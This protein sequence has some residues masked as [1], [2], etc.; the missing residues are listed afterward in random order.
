[1]IFYSQFLGLFFFSNIVEYEML[2]D[3]FFFL[4][5]VIFGLKKLQQGRL[6]EVLCR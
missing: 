4:I 5:C 6:N 1:M 3:F 2:G